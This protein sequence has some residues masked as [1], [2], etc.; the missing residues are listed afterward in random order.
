MGGECGREGGG[1]DGVEWGGKWDNCNSIINKYIKKKKVPQTDWLKTTEI[2]CSQISGDWKSEIKV[3]GRAMLSQKLPEDSSLPFPASSSFRHSLAYDSI[4]PISSIAIFHVFTWH[5][6][7]CVCTN[8]R[9]IIRIPVT[10]DQSQR[11]DLILVS[12]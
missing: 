11:N 4:I 6:C 3:L 9:L 2:Y 5:F 1:Q 7:V 10:L 12:Q 8:S